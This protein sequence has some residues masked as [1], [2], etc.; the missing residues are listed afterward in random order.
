MKRKISRTKKVMAETKPPA[1][2][3][4]A[5]LKQEMSA[6]IEDKRN[7]EGASLTKYV[8]SATILEKDV[9]AA[10]AR[11]HK[12]AP[13][14]RELLGEVKNFPWGGDSPIGLKLIMTEVESNL[15][16]ITT[17][18]GVQFD[19]CLTQIQ[20]ASEAVKRHQA[21]TGIE[22]TAF[23]ASIVV[24]QIRPK[25]MGLL[26][27]PAALERAI[28]RLECAFQETAE[29]FVAARRQNIP[30]PRTVAQFPEQPKD[31]VTIESNLANR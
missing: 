6:L 8:E 3:R 11:Y 10:R 9:I 26:G 29:G 21:M 7:E 15:S 27:I 12:L 4:I 18:T 24:G 20:T 23:A 16:S 14:A 17:P 25:A 2:N 19:E 30:S 13:R 22:D 5:E 1:V 31:D 28:K